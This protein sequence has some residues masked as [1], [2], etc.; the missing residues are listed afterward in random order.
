[1]ER[2]QEQQSHDDQNARGKTK[3]DDSVDRR[4]DSKGV[5]ER[6]RPPCRRSESP[7]G[8]EMR[9]RYY[10]AGEAL[11]E[12]IRQV[13][14]EARIEHVGG[15]L[16]P[17]GGV[18]T[19]RIRQLGQRAVRRAKRQKRTR[20][21][22]NKVIFAKPDF[23]DTRKVEAMM[24]Y[25]RGVV[26]VGGDR[27]NR[28]KNED[29]ISA[30]C[31]VMPEVDGVAICDGACSNCLYQHS[32]A[33]C[34][35]RGGPAGEGSK[36]RG[37]GRVKGGR[38]KRG[39][40]AVCGNREVKE[41]DERRVKQCWGA[42]SGGGLQEELG[43]FKEGLQRGRELK[44]IGEQLATELGGLMDS[45]GIIGGEQGWGDIQG[46][47]AAMVIRTTRMIEEVLQQGVQLEGLV[48]QRIERM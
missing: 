43:K 25:E 34:N 41:G 1:M 11:F 18:K 32:G 39:R 21:V 17:R 7:D 35:A 29:G 4:V 6:R 5:T 27:C 36:A 24:V 48:I 46:A 20:V 3:G 40:D 8:Y 16:P 45:T 23:R 31:V 37:V 12:D 19:R 26:R 15:M 28:C 13:K 42:S 47:L 10:E 30:D 22:G 9:S 44:L 14:K 38:G 2:R 33:G